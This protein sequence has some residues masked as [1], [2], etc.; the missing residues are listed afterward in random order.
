MTE[1]W[2][3]AVAIY[4]GSICKENADIMKHA[5]LGDELPVGAQFR[6]MVY[7][8]KRLARHLFAMNNQQFFQLRIIYDILVNYLIWFHILC[9]CYANL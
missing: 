9:F 7:H 5:G 8:S 1:I 6:M 3:L 2:L 4:S